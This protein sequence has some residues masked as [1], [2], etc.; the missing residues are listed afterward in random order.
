MGI[1]LIPEL[2][3]EIIYSDFLFNTRMSVWFPWC[4]ATQSW[5]R[6]HEPCPPLLLPPAGNVSSIT[7]GSDSQKA[8]CPVLSALCQFPLTGHWTQNK[9]SPFPWWRWAF[10]STHEVLT[11]SYV[12]CACE[13]RCQRH[14]VPQSWGCLKWILGT[15]L[16][17]SGRAESVLIAEPPLQPGKLVLNNED[18]FLEESQ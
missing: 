9:P 2:A 7:D 14:W 3:L 17:S 16:R 12:V 15:G 1:N 18:L 11:G 13:R 10:R 8:M 4:T 6:T 5:L